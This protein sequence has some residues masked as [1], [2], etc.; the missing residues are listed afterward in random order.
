M[1]FVETVHTLLDPAKRVIAFNCQRKGSSQA[2]KKRPRAWKAGLSGLRM[3]NFALSL[4]LPVSLCFIIR[5]LRLARNL[6]SSF[7][8]QLTL[9]ARREV[10]FPTTS[11]MFPLFVMCQTTCQT[12]YA[13]LAFPP[14]LEF[15]I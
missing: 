7:L 10:F 4:S 2:R 1:G 3:L 9:I 15:R 12:F 5:E 6:F 11:K 14:S 13:L 8:N